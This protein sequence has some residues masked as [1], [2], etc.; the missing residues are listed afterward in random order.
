VMKNP[1]TEQGVKRFVEH[2]TL[3]LRTQP[4]PTFSGV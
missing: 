1:F 3:R 4:N 2:A